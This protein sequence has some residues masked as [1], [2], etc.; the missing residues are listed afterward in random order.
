MEPIKLDL[1]DSDTLLAQ[2]EELIKKVY[3]DGYNKG[4]EEGKASVEKRP[5]FLG[6]FFGMDAPFLDD[7]DID[8]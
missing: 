7:E 1:D 4:F 8:I 6:D 5:M 3:Q 2:I